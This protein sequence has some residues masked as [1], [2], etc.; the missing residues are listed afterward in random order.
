MYCKHTSYQIGARVNSKSGVSNWNDYNWINIVLVTAAPASDF[1]ITVRTHHTATLNVA[2]KS[3]RCATGYGYP[4]C[5]F[6]P[7]VQQTDVCECWKSLRG[8]R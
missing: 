5:T 4:A 8:P 7:A 3:G 6:G 2:S 1:L